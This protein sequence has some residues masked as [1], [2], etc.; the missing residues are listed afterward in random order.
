[1]PELEETPLSFKVSS[2]LKADL[3]KL[4]DADRRSLSQYLRIVLEE[5]VAAN[6]AAAK[7][8]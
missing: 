2:S 1:M 6:K 4:A 8:K 5:H 3:Q 7:R